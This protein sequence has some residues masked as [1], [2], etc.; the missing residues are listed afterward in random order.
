MLSLRRD[1]FATINQQDNPKS[2]SMLWFYRSS[3]QEQFLENSVFV[4]DSPNVGSP[5]TMSQKGGWKSWGRSIP[6]D[7]A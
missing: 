2:N 7:F 6:A 4:G 5:S 3:P 1:S